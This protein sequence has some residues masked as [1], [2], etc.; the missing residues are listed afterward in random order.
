M[1]KI[2]EYGRLRAEGYDHDAALRGSGIT[3]AIDY[4]AHVAAG[5]SKADAAHAAGYASR[6]NGDAKAL[7]AKALSIKTAT[8]EVGATPWLCPDH[9]RQ[10]RAELERRCGELRVMEDACMALALSECGT[11][12]SSRVGDLVPCPQAV[13]VCGDAG[14]E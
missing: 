4:A 2:E 6:P 13:A 11:H 14:S 12:Q 5:S 7:A 9:Y 8:R 1:S 10:Q 3:Q